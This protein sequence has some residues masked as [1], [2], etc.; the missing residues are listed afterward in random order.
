MA[1]PYPQEIAP[2]QRATTETDRFKGKTVAITGPSLHGIGGAVA[3]RMATEGASL[4]MLA[5]EKPVDLMDRLKPVGTSVHWTQC[6]VTDAVGA[7]AAIE[8]TAEEFGELDILVN[9]AG[10]D[11]ASP[12]AEMDESQWRQIVEVNFLGV[13]R[14]SQAMLLHLQKRKGVIVNISSVT[15][16]AGTAGLAA[17]GASKSAVNSLTQSLAIEYASRH[18][19]VVGVAPALV[20]T[21]MIAP[22]VENVTAEDWQAIQ[23]CHPLGIGSP[24]DVAAAVAFLASDEARWISGVTLPMGWMPNWS[25]PFLKS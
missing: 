18:V 5:P 7:R 6:D 2:L 24:E 11:W 23:Q 9:N 17:Y 14:M 12:F 8:A 1:T 13:L 3:L 25:M 20:R 4:A 10:V 15:A 16:F 19:R 22:Y 21:P